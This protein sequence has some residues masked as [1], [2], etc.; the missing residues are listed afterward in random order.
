MRYDISA[1]ITT[2]SYFWSGTPDDV[3][4]QISGTAGTTEELM[5][6]SGTFDET[7]GTTVTCT[8][9]STVDI[10]DYTCVTWRLD[11]TNGVGIAEFTTSVDGVEQGTVT[12]TDG[13]LDNTSGSS[14][15]GSNGF[16]AIWCTG[17]SKNAIF[18]LFQNFGVL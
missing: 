4:V 12:P 10:G 18:E 16:T 15:H 11:G 3:Y 2:S 6:L 1:T 8:V 9:T 17:T 13:W 14:S 5:C 7:S